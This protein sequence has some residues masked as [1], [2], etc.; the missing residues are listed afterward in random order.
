MIAFISDQESDESGSFRPQS[1]ML[2]LL[3]SFWCSLTTGRAQLSTQP[4]SFHQLPAPIPLLKFSLLFA[5]R[6]NPLC[7][8]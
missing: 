1:L 7:Y 2:E 8:T 6:G 3:L 5:A 4:S